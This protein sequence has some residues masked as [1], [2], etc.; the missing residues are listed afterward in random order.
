MPGR[1]RFSFPNSRGR[2]DPWFRVGSVDVTTTV[3]ITALCVLSFF[4]WAA[5]PSAV[6]ALAQIPSDVTSGQVWRLITWPIANSPDLRVVIAI[7]IFWYM[8]SQVENLLGRA[9]FSWLLGLT[10]LIPGLLGVLLDIPQAGIGSIELAVFVVFICEY[11]KAPFFFGIPAWVLG[12]V[13]VG[14]DILRLLGARRPEELILYLAG[15][16]TAVW[17]ARSMGMLTSLQWL[18]PIKVPSL[19]S[20][21]KNAPAL[22]GPGARPSLWMDP[23]PPARRYTPR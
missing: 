1:Y 13:I 21:S 23:G 20:G 7:A 12:A 6:E 10:T 3:L 16:A 18:P 9:K 2:T 19:K 5:S 22:P 8:G 17:A 15:I 4:V 14:I 11:P